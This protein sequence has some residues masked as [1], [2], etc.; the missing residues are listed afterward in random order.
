M[1]FSQWTFSLETTPS[2]TASLSSSS[3]LQGSSSVVIT[4]VDNQGRWAFGY[5]PGLVK[6]CVFLRALIRCDGDGGPFGGN[7]YDPIGVFAQS[8]GAFSW[9]CNAYSMTIANG[10]ATFGAASKTVLHKGALGSAITD[11]TGVSNASMTLPAN[12]VCSAIGLKCEH[13]STS[14]NMFLTAYYDPGPISIPVASSYTFPNLAAQCTYLDTSSPYTSGV[15]FGVFGS[16]RSGTSVTQT[17][18][19]IVMSTD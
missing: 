17:F 1:S 3:P 18:D 8:Q 15:T 10:L 11:N 9:N 4:V 13:D 19:L 7:D 16:N 5:T 14:G 6:D 2:L 12:H